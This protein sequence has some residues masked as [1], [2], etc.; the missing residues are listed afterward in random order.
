MSAC[1]LVNKQ[2]WT[3]YLFRVFNPKIHFF[4]KSKMLKKSEK[5]TSLFRSKQNIA[6]PE[7]VTQIVDSS[8]V[9]PSDDLSHATQSEDS[10]LVTQ[11]YSVTTGKVSTLVRS[12]SFSTV[13]TRSSISFDGD[14]DDESELTVTSKVTNT[15]SKVTNTSS[16]VPNNSSLVP[17]KLPTL[18]RTLSKS[19]TGFW[20]WQW[21]VLLVNKVCFHAF[22]F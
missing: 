4:A 5:F 1:R 15:S 7:R 22:A 9:T 18:N 2:S 19:F 10:V 12:P 20:S 11:C 17:H 8:R 16:T 14:G 21:S 6:D 13:S 3:S